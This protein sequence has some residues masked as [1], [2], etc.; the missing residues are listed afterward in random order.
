MTSS[1]SVSQAVLAPRQLTYFTSLL[2]SRGVFTAETIEYALPS[3]VSEF[4]AY[5]LLERTAPD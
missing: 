1:E 2:V 4:Q 3:T 5:E